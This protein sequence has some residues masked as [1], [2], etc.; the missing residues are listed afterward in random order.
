MCNSLARRPFS[1][2]EDIKFILNQNANGLTKAWK[3]ESMID[4]MITNNIDAYLIQ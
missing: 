3:M 4:N 1:K 2:Q